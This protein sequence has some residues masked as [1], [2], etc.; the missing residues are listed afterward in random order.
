MQLREATQAD[1]E[2]MTGA[3][4]SRGQKELPVC[5]DLTYCMENDGVILGI[6]GMKLMTPSVA[7]CWMDWSPH[8]M[9]HLYSGYRMLTEWLD[10]MIAT[11]KIKRLMAAVECDFHQAIRT[12]EHLGFERE[13]IMKNWTEHRPAF[14]YVRLM[15]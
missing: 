1:L 10:T 2:Y 15:E 7:W 4:I 6:G 12:V 5:I 13:S 3:S 11:H 8:A 14:L 9:E